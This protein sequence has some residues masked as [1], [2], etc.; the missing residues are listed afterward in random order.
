MGQRGNFP[1]VL[2][3]HIADV[4]S[5]AEREG[6]DLRV[7]HTSSPRSDQDGPV[8]IVRQRYIDDGRFLELT[9]A[10]EDWGKEVYR[11]GL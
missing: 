9:V 10:A 6:I 11:N 5:L 3:Y 7:K 4:V 1:D 2:A 8:R